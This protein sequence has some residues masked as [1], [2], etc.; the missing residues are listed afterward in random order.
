MFWL[1]AIV[2]NEPNFDILQMAPE[3]LTVNQLGIAVFPRTS[4]FA[5]RVDDDFSYISM[6]FLHWACT[7]SYAWGWK[8]R[9]KYLK[10]PRVYYPYTRKILSGICVS[11][12]PFF[13][14]PISQTFSFLWHINWLSRHVI[15][16]EHTHKATFL[17]WNLHFLRR[18]SRS[19]R[20]KEIISKREKVGRNSIC[21]AIKEYIGIV[22]KFSAGFQ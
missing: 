9:L 10:N 21:K 6:P 18:D 8:K 5:L 11:A 22:N 13:F 17:N 12:H 4:I 20:E 16:R 19:K 15:I 7:L 3:A 2:R 1:Y 14:R